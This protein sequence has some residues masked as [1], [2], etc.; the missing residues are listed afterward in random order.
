MSYKS[1][2][3][4]LKSSLLALFLLFLQPGFAQ[5]DTAQLSQVLQSKQKVLGK[6]LVM[7][8]WKKD[9][10]LIYKKEAGDFNSKTVAPIASCSKWLTAALLMQ[11]VDEGKLSLD[12]KITRW[13]PEFEKY[14]KNYIT[15]R[16][17]LSH[18]TGIKDESSVLGKIFQRRQPESLEEQVNWFAAREIRT[19]PGTDFW[20]GNIGLNIVGRVLEVISKKKFDVLIKTKLFMPMGMRKTTFST[21]DNSAVNPSGGAVSTAD[22]YMR[23]LVMLMNKGKFGGKQILSEESVNQLMQV[24]T[25]SS[26]IKYAPKPAQGYNYALGSWVAEESNG[27]ATT[28]ACPGLFGTWPMIDFCRGYAYLVFVKNLLGEEKAEAHIAL[29]KL[30]DE[31]MPSACP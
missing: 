27:K 25:N 4:C 28:L 22:E 8:L 2:L 10:T 3:I 30:I 15:I 29:K 7:M 21:M 1:S 26:Q 19:N 31:H 17:C 20:Y 24:Q 23:F 6:D 16:L 12:D 9:D 11:F 18:M 13:L 14:N 5:I